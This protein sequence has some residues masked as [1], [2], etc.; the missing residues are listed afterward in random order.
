MGAV[1]TE[2]GTEVLY[3]R[4]RVVLAARAAGIIAI[5]QAVAQVRDDDLYRRDAAMGRNLGY[6]GKMCVLPRQL[7][8]C[9]EVFSPA[10]AEVDYSRRL[11]AAYAAAEAQGIGT[12]AFEGKLLDGPIL[13]RARDVVAMTERLAQ[14]ATQQ[15]EGSA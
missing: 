6:H 8:L 13:R 14:R 1:R 7:A 9:H 5:D 4:S 10:A 11:L 15:K 3:V 2:E 12:I